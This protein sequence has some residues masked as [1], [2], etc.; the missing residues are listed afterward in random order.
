M[1]RPE[2]LGKLVHQSHCRWPEISD[3][4]NL[5]SS[6][7]SRGLP[8]KHMKTSRKPYGSRDKTPR[9]RTCGFW[10]GWG[11]QFSDCRSRKVVDFP[12]TIGGRWCPMPPRAQTMSVPLNQEHSGVC[13]K[14]LRWKPRA[15]LTADPN[16]AA[17]QQ[18]GSPEEE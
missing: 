10:T 11:A 18:V 7:S 1:K 5:K 6:P 16:E 12:G 9:R 14:K 13:W 4:Q 8:A 17:A 3:S 2:I 15:F